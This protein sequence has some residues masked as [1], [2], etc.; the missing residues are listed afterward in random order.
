MPLK[1]IVKQH[2]SVVLSQA[3]DVLLGRDLCAAA[4]GNQEDVRAKRGAKR[5][6]QSEIASLYQHWTTAN[7][8]GTPHCHALPLRYYIYIYSTG[9]ATY[10]Y[11][12]VTSMC[13]TCP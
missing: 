9:A 6:D 4:A 12:L 13:R 2:I 7:I 5:W 10:T 11:C 8:R 1:K 3:E